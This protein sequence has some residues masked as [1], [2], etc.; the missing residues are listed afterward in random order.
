VVDETRVYPIPMSV[1]FAAAAALPTVYYTAHLSLHHRAQLKPGET[2][3]ILGGS[4]GVGCAAIQIAR[5]AGCRVLATATGEEKLDLCRRL[6][7][8]LAIDY[9][10]EDLVQ[11]VRAVTDDEGA[12]VVLDPVGGDLSDAARRVVAWEGR[13]VI[14]GFVAGRIPRAPTN[15]VLLKNYS[16]LGFNLGSYQQRQPDLVRA[17][18]DDLMRLAETGVID[19]PIYRVYD[20]QAAREAF[21]AMD[22]REHWGKIVVQVNAL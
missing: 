8:D 7:A 17:A 13:M 20:F 18:H 14:L 10:H 1:S 5:A 2:V 19:P 6:G 15:H 16:L 3:L 9:K 22:A 12:D 21:A 4:G 11:V